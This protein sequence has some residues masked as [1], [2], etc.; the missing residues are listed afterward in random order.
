MN[1]NRSTRYLDKSNM[2]GIKSREGKLWG[3]L[4]DKTIIV[5]AQAGDNCSILPP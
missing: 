3:V 1:V 2:G 5:T 4:G